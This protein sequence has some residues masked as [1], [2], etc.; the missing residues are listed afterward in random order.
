M[1]AV[2]VTIVTMVTGPKINI[3]ANTLE[4]HAI[5]IWLLLGDL[6]EFVTK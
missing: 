6:A 5:S 3:L 4:N 2:A 1:S